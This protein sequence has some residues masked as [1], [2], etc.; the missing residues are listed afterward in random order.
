MCPQGMTAFIPES[1]IYRFLNMTLESVCVNIMCNLTHTCWDS[2]SVINL[3]T[4]PLCW[5]V[6]TVQL[7]LCLGTH[8]HR[9]PG[10]IAGLFHVTVSEVFGGSCRRQTIK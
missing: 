10:V 2:V 3:W 5:C 9:I 4:S 7:P 8:G 6:T 1:L